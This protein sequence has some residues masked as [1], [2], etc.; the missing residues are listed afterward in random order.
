L[1]AGYTRL[2]VGVALGYLLVILIDRFYTLRLVDGTPVFLNLGSHL[3]LAALCLL[4][5]GTAYA[6]HVGS[7]SARGLTLVASI[8][9]AILYPVGTIVFLYWLVWVRRRERAV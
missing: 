2:L 6:R 7:P 4:L 1:E 9:S 5:L 8:L 3:A